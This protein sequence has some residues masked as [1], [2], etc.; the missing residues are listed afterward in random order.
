MMISTVNPNSTDAW[1]AHELRF[2]EMG[3]RRLNQRLISVVASLAA[4]PAA[5]VPQACGSWAATKATY[6]FWASDRVTPAAIRAAHYQSVADRAAQHATIL[7]IQDT[8]TL[9]F[10]HHPATRNLGPIH[11]TPYQ[12]GMHIHSVLAAT[13]DGVPLGLLH[14]QVWARDAATAGKKHQRHQ[15]ETV[16]KESQR[17]LTALAATQTSLAPTVQVVTIADREAD[18]FDLFAHPRPSHSHLLIRAA[19]NRRVVHPV[20]HLWPRLRTVAVGGQL[21]LEVRRGDDAPARIVTLTLRWTAIALAAPG[22][23]KGHTKIPPVPLYGVLAE[24]E[25]PAPGCSPICWLLLTTLPVASWDDAVRTV[26][27]YARRWLVER[28]HFVLKSGCRVEHLQLETFDRLERA[29]ATYCIVA[30]RLLWLTYQARTQPDA[31]CEVALTRPE[32]QV[33]YCMV[34]ATLV[35]P[36]APPSLHDA[37]QWIAG[38]GGFLGRKGDGAPGVQVIWRGLQRLHDM[39]ATW[40]LLHPDAPHLPDLSYG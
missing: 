7:A 17:W 3:D 16:D 18:I 21:S 32:W 8:T 33:L 30:W 22:H 2:A 35:P 20:R 40:S 11:G 28:Y 25:E 14:Q 37:V 10:T 38:L 5:S 1:A 39:A 6:R 9:D 24:E 31:P 15:R 36:S 27:W 26:Q 19:Y 29:L 23:R 34:H 4:Q 12:Q 13:P